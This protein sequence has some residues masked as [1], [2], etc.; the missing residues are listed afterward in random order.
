MESSL[1]IKT[2]N[3]APFI[4]NFKWGQKKQKLLIHA[5]LHCSSVQLEDI[6]SLIQVPTQTLEQVYNGY[7][8][9]QS[10]HALRLVQLFLI[11]FTD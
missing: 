2:L 6:G 4:L 8:Y 3:N 11:R 7:D 5:L 9:L 1:E 10:E